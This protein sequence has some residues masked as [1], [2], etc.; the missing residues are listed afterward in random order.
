MMKDGQNIIN[1]ENVNRALL[2]YNIKESYDKQLKMINDHSFK[3]RN[4]N[5]IYEKMLTS[6]NLNLKIY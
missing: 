2:L 5:N 6:L 1:E 4:N 3:I